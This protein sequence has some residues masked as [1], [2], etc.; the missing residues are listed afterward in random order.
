MEVSEGTKHGK[1]SYSEEQ[2][3]NFAS[4][5]RD[6][7]NENPDW[8]QKQL[9]EAVGIS[10]STVYRLVKK[11]GIGYVKKQRVHKQEVQTISGD[12]LKKLMGRHPEWTISQL[13]YAIGVPDE[14]IVATMRKFNIEAPK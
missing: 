13:A 4:Q 6:L 11:Y 1:I 5:L 14:V 2:K 3:R 12:R 10:Q 8:S 9:A 7:I